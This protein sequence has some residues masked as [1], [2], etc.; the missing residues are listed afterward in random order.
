MKEYVEEDIEYQGEFKKKLIAPTLDKLWGKIEK[1][2][3]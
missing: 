2:I 3:C 1:I